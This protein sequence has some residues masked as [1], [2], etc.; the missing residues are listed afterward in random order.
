M[1]AD[2]MVMASI[3]VHRQ[4]LQIDAGKRARQSDG[5]R[6]PDGQQHGK[7]HQEPGAKELHEGKVSRRASVSVL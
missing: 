1:P 7:N 2:C 5:H 4:A 3:V 6:T